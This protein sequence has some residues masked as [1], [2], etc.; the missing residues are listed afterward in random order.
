MSEQ[1]RT[2][3]PNATATFAIRLRVTPEMT[4]RFFDAS[5]HPLYATFAIVEHAE[6]V[7]RCL[8][9]SYLMPEE[10]AVGS[11]VEVRH[12]APAGVGALITHE[13]R[14]R[15]E[16]KGRIVCEVEVREGERVIAGCVTTQQVL[17]RE[18][19]EAMYHPTR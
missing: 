6:Y 5:V 13:A 18:K 7:S 2:I 17:P 3:I 15:E 9:R 8:I 11:S 16:K 10:D 12:I 4:A 14:F 1:H 19:V